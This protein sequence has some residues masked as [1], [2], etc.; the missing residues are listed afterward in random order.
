MAYDLKF[1]TQTMCRWCYDFRP[2]LALFGPNNERKKEG[3][4]T[5][6]RIVGFATDVSCYPVTKRS[7]VRVRDFPVTRTHTT[8]IRM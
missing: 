1:I 8:D 4:L 6:T 7:I 3:Q 2:V 5:L